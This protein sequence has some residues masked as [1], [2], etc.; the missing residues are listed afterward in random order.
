MRIE[1]NITKETSKNSH[2]ARNPT[3][4][5]RFS[6]GSGLCITDRPVSTDLILIVGNVWHVSS[7]LTNIRSDCECVVAVVGS[8]VS[9]LRR[10]TGKLASYIQTYNVGV[11]YHRSYELYW[12]TSE[13]K[14]WKLQLLTDFKDHS[15]SD[16]FIRIRL[17]SDGDNDDA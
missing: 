6:G 11:N 8:V 9:W 13:R 7:D 17:T 4:V 2:S 12:S 15:Q 5:S 14:A 1:L 16:W 3:W 10:P